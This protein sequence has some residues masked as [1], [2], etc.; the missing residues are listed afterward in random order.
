M[1]ETGFNKIDVSSTP[2]RKSTVANPQSQMKKKR[3]TFFKTRK[4]KIIGAIV[5]A[6]ILL[7]AYIGVNTFIFLSDAN[8]AY[9]QAKIAYDAIKQQNVVVA[10]EELVKTQKQLA[11]LQRDLVPIAFLGYIPFFGG[12]YNDV[13]NLVD[14]SSHGINAGITATDSLIPY[15]DVLGLKGD[16]SFAQGSAEDRIRLAIKTMDKVVPKIDTI[17]KDLIAAKQATDKVNPNRYPSIGKLKKVHDSLQ[18]L[19][20]IVDGSVIAVEQGK[21]LIK[22]L[23]DL[24]GANGE[25]KYLVLFQNDKELRPTGGFMT[26]Y[27]VFRLE[28]GVI[29]VDKAGDIYTLDDSLPSHQP[30]P[31][32]IAKYLPKVDTFNIRDSNLSPDFVESMKT[33]NKMYNT[34]RD[35]ADIDGIIA[36]D[37]HFLVSI[38]DVLGDVQAGGLTFNS[39]NDPR[40]DC[41]QAVFV[42][43]DN[44]T[45]PVNYIK[46]NRKGLLAELLFAI[47]Q[48]ALSSSPKEYWGN[49]MQTAINDAQEKH[50]M[51]YLFNPEAQKGID[52]LG[53]SGAIKP[54][55]GDYLHINDSNFGGAKSN[56]FVEQNVRVDFKIDGNG[57][58]TK[59][60]TISYKNPK[61]HSDCNLEH[62]ELCLNATLRDFQRVYVP[63]GS[64]LISS[65][66]SEVKTTVKEDLGKTDFESFLTVNPLGSAKIIYEYK[67][68]FK[69]EGKTLPFLIQK[70]PGTDAV[71]YEIY[72]NGNKT[73][74]FNLST[75]REI[76][77]PVR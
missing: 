11:V 57:E 69:V 22:L 31:P 4:Q 47:I 43:E 5:L 74:A 38:L 18:D 36:I 67:L 41:P 33:F 6:V 75:D 28:Q 24:L 59:T 72:V 45:K 61:P 37:T 20:N 1:E 40:C 29:H 58:V 56:L 54:F 7:I 15:A 50:V 71:P 2:V 60:L 73:D 32:I 9:A 21:P 55:E 51:F 10:K 25:K 66:G 26:F 39:N 49:L 34:S 63:K 27:A 62:G 8:K 19:K 64:T 30:A 46:T 12:Y 53:W 16:K 70:Q 76:Q 23:P 35:K 3:I 77:I 13:K 17:E 52:A 42:L 44:T 14:A 65:K 68:P 48:K